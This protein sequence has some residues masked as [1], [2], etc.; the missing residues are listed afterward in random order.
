MPFISASAISPYNSIRGGGGGSLVPLLLDLYPDAAAAYSLRKLR[1]GYNGD[2]IR[3]RIDTTGQPTYDIGFDS[4]G[5]LDTASLLSFAG[6]NDA[7]VHTWYDQSGG[8]GNDVTQVAANNQPKI[9]S[10]G[11]I[12]TVNNASAV[13]FNGASNWIETPNFTK[14]E[15]PTSYFGVFKFDLNKNQNIFDGSPTGRQIIGENGTNYKIFGG[16]QII[17]GITNTNQNSFNGI[18][19]ATD[20]LFINNISVTSGNAGSNG[21][22]KILIGSNIGNSSAFVNGKIQEFILYPSDQTTNRTAIE[23]NINKN[24]NIYWDGSQT[25]LLDDYPNASAAYSLRAL[26]SAY[27]G[28]LITVRRSSDN[29]TQDI[30]AKYD[31]S[32]D[33]DSLLTFVGSGDG[34]VS[35]WYDQSGGGN[36]AVQ[37][38]AAYQSKIVDAG[39]VIVNPTNNLPSILSGDVQIFM[40][41]PSTP[42]KNMFVVSELQA[43]NIV[44]YITFQGASTGGMFLGGQLSSINGF[45]VFRSGVVKSDTGEDLNLNLANFYHNGTGYLVSKNNGALTDIGSTAAQLSIDQILGRNSAGAISSLAYNQEIIIYSSGDNLNNNSIKENINDYYTI[46]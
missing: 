12:I 13:Y 41:I 21:I 39:S 4:N 18:F 33:A 2:A 42:T 8:G 10:N 11:V 26:S 6:S 31:G 24:Y 5:E 17:G 19:S 40:N 36:D 23:T 46:Y 35:T 25:G 34:F 16:N 1:S 28:A 32:L 44:N 27:T 7:Y 30:Y 3:V 22:D 37:E 20:S 9:V 14:I 15:Q 45:G 43:I 38:S 29:E